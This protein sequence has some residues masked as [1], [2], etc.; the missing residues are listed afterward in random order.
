[1]SELSPPLSANPDSFHDFHRIELPKRLAAG[2]GPLAHPAVAPLGALALATPAGS[3]TYRPTD[4]SVE[5]VAGD[6]TADTVIEIGLD[7]WLG[8]SPT[9]T[10]PPVSSTAVR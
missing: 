8:W 3:Y 2:N 4:E 6:D 7:A 1:M 9:S 5:V 10:P